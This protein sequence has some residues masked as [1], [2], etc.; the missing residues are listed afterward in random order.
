MIDSI[1]K[2]G[3]PRGRCLAA[4]SIVT[5]FAA[6][7]PL[8]EAFARQR[9]PGTTSETNMVDLRTL[10]DAEELSESEYE[11]MED[12]LATPVTGTLRSE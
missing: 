9:C 3:A 1:Q 4:L 8:R 10:F 6:C 7:H 2:L 11:Y 12:E 5:C